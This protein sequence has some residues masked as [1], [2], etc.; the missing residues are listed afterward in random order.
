MFAEYVNVLARF[1][2]YCGKDENMYSFILNRYCVIFT[3]NVTLISYAVLN[4]HLCALFIHN[5]ER[6]KLHLRLT[7][8]M[9]HCC[10]LASSLSL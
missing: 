7:L 1:Y 9:T 6:D 3:T 2:L 5:V 8:P 4:E 10:A